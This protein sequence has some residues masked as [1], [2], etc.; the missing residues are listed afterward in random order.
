MKTLIGSGLVVAGLLAVGGS[1]ASAQIDQSM[2]FTTTFPF[3]VGSKMLPAGSYT[4]GPADG[5]DLTVLEVRG[6]GGSAM[7][8][9]ENASVPRIDPKQDEVI[10]DKSGDHYVLT[11]VWDES[12]RQGA[13]RI[14][15]RG[16]R[17]E[18]A[19]LVHDK[20]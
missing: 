15:S 13:E 3:M 20:Q 7:F 2:K 4:V 18:S 5:T 17:H 8:S 12:S 6:K 10:F 14:P 19:T 1:P 16:E 11:E 9:T